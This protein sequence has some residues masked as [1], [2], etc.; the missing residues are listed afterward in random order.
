MAASLDKKRGINDKETDKVTNFLAYMLAVVAVTL[1]VLTTGSAILWSAKVGQANIL[2]TDA[3]CA[4]YTAA[5]PVIEPVA[6]N[7]HGNNDG[8][9]QKVAFEH[10]SADSVLDA[11]RKLASAPTQTATAEYFLSIFKE[12]MLFNYKTH[13][14]VLSTVNESVPETAIMLLMPIL[15]PLYFCCMVLANWVVFG[16]QW[17]AQLGWL[18][19]QRVAGQTQ[20]FEEIGALQSP[21]SFA[22][23]TIVAFWIVMLYLAILMVPVPVVTAIALFVIAVVWLK[24]LT[25]VGKQGGQDYGFGSFW[26]STLVYNRHILMDAIALAAIIGVSTWFGSVPA[27]ITSAVLLFLWLEVLPIPIF[28]SSGPP[29]DSM[30]IATAFKKAKRACPVPPATP[31]RSSVFRDI[32]NIL[33]R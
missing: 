15:A 20:G 6:V 2:P 3:D 12:L 23:A 25:I 28:K 10:K 18:F 9:S 19:K 27:V 26:A 31:P 22:F 14:W 13:E 16:Y 33:A 8:M 7:I 24:P 29:A 17:F 21:L 32:L 11:W 30:S 1:L 5:E 4:P